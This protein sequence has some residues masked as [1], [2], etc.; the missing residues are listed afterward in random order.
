MPYWEPAKLLA[1]IRRHSSSS[2][3]ALLL[4]NPDSGH[5]ESDQPQSVLQQAAQLWAFAAHCIH[6]AVAV[7]EHASC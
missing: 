5:Q 1:N 4:L 6:T 7:E 3:P 2:A